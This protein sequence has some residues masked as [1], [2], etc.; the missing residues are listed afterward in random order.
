LTRIIRLSRSEQAILKLLV[1]G[2]GPAQIARVL[3]R[4]DGK[5]GPRSARAVSGVIRAI[6]CKA[7]VK[8]GSR[9]VMLWGVAHPEALRGEAVYEW[10][11]Y[12]WPIA[13]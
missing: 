4:F 2:K 10:P 6:G 5:S 13:A 12:E 1:E 3:P 11:V 7:G 9:Q 8:G